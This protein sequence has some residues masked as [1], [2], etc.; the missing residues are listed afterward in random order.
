[1]S[2]KLIRYTAGEG[3]SWGVA[4]PRRDRAAAR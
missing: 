4:A 1:M 2:I 3:P